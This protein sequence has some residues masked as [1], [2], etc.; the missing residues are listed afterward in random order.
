MVNKQTMTVFILI[1][2]EKIWTSKDLDVSILC[3][4]WV[5]LDPEQA[6]PELLLSGGSDKRVR[7]WKR[8]EGEE[9][10]LGHLKMFGMF[11]AQ[12]GVIL[13]LAQNSTYLA[14]ASG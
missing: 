2:A 10:M 14:T 4:M 7:V 9:G 3:L 6:E 1:I 11:G 13:T 12:Q 5:V 8:K